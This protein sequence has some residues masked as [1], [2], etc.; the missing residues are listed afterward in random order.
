MAFDKQFA[1]E[2]LFHDLPDAEAEKIAAILP[3]QPFT[4]FTTPVHWD[5][6]HD[7][8]FRGKLGYIF[9]DRDSILPLEVQEM[10]VRMG[11]VEKTR[12]LE[13]SSHAPH[14]EKPDELAEM[15]L[16]LVKEILGD[17]KP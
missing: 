3:K 10:Y 12:L 16:D 2:M 11:G 14:V 9:T 17:D 5:P 13:N 4:C 1:K 8:N 6:Y 7:S 15:V